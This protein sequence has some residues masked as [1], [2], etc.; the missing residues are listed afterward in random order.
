MLRPDD[1]IVLA[2]HACA[3]LTPGS[4]EHLARLVEF[5]HARFEHT[6]SA[7]L[8]SVP[9][10]LL[11]GRGGWCHQ[12]VAV[13]CWLLHEG[14]GLYAEGAP[15]R[16]A[17][18]D[19]HVVAA[20][21]VPDGVPST[22]GWATVDVDH[23]HVYTAPDGRLAHPLDL[24]HWP[25]WVAA[26]RQPCSGVGGPD[27]GYFSRGP[28]TLNFQ[29]G[30]RCNARCVMCWQSLRRDEAHRDAWWSEMKPEVVESI[31]ARHG[32]EV[33]S[34]ELVSFGE[35]MLNPGF[36]RMLAAVV[37][38]SERHKKPIL[39]N[40]ITNGSLLH[41]HPL[42]VTLPGYLTV[43]I[44]AADPALYERIRVGLDWA[45]VH[46][47]LA[48]AAS[49][50]R[51]HKDRKIGVNL[52]LFE[53]NADQVVPMARLCAEL[54]LSY[55]SILYG[56]LLSA[57][58]A[59]GRQIRQ[60]DPRLVEGVAEAR[61]RCPVLTINDYATGRSLPVIEVAAPVLPGRGFCPLPWRQFDVGPDGQA[62]PCCR[63]HG[64]DLGDAASGADVWRSPAFERLRAQILGDDVDPMEFGECARCPNLGA[65]V[66]GAG[67][68][69]VVP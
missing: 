36:D 4:R 17:N 41:R 31:L 55:L 25:D 15:L 6:E 7:A 21:H 34:V 23:G 39:L 27:W 26:E 38:A 64:T 33:D 66:R 22:S 58:A 2:R 56:D 20:V 50:P 47:N 1:W 69:P 9:A 5:V 11:N 28:R 48:A 65:G 43:S 60:D 37:A 57:T 53:D 63:S 52:T 54:G 14:W 68:L 13:Y 12:S 8:S 35:P 46:G 3:S 30:D 45:T 40:A 61:V 62:H 29:I 32:G 16:A 44:D 67:H 18:G 42:L 24:A 51:R 10:E 49:D 59:A 19:G